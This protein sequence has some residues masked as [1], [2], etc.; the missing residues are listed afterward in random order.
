VRTG[1][2]IA[3]H[4]GRDRNIA[5]DC[6]PVHTAAFSR[7]SLPSFDRPWLY[8]SLLTLLAAGALGAFWLIRRGLRPYAP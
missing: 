1:L 4:C 3:G 6:A 8:L 5:A 7:F 2:S